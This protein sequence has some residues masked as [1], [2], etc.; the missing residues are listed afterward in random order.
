MVTL[1]KEEVKLLQ[2][3]LNENLSL[4]PALKVDGIFGKTTK[5]AVIAFQEKYK[6]EV[7]I[8]WKSFGLKDEKGTGIVY[9]TTL[10]WINMVKCSGLN[11]PMPQLP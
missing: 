4:N 7:L 6:D 5:T 9:K 8:P 1:N 3:F 11:I 10:R 2:S